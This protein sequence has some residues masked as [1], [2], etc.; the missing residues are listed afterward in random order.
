MYEV[1]G[2]KAPNQSPIMPRNR[3]VPISILMHPGKRILKSIFHLLVC[4]PF[5]RLL[6]KQMPPVIRDDRLRHIIRQIHMAEPAVAHAVPV[7]YGRLMPD[8]DFIQGMELLVQLQPP[9]PAPGI[10]PGLEEP[11]QLRKPLQEETLGNPVL[12]EALFIV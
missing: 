9:V 8:E 1:V 3:Q 7:G 2:F 6:I 12:L 11:L 10:A 4:K 5:Q